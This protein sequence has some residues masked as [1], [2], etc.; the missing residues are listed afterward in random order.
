MLELLRS[1]RIAAQWVKSTISAL[2]GKLADLKAAAG[3]LDGSPATPASGIAALRRL[4]NF[5]LARRQVIR[6]F[7]SS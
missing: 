1:A 5:P 6:L 4:A 2:H 7:G 3:L